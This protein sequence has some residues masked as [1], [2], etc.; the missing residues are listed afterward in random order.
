MSFAKTN[1]GKNS[2]CK[3]FAVFDEASVKDSEIYLA[4][5]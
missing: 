3:Y 2:S 4:N 1:N 5:K